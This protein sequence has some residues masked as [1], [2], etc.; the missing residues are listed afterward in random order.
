MED[1]SAFAKAQHTQKISIGFYNL[2]NLFDTTNNPN[3]LDDDFTPEG[4][5]KWNEYKYEKKLE[6]LSQVISKISKS[7]T[8]GSPSLL[9]VAEVENKQVLEDLIAT[10]YLQHENYGIVHYDSPDERG[11]DVALLY[12]KTDFEVLETK[13]IVLL[14]EATEGGRDYTRDILYVKGLLLGTEVHLLINHWPSRR[15]GAND[16][17][18]KRIAAAKRN[19]EI[20]DALL[21]ENAEARILLMGDFNDGP[22]SESIKTHL[23][24]TD[25]YNPML[26]LG[27]RYAGS[28]NHNFEWFIFDQILMTNNFVRMYDNKLLYEKSDIFNDYFIT[29]FDGRFKGNPFRTYAGDR[30][31]GGYSDHFPVYSVFKVTLNSKNAS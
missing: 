15:L 16:T 25:F 9:G 13:P 19:R 3:I 6:K 24:Q 1:T 5:R 8:G 28:L 17:Q 7:E 10:G 30:Y 22:H 29:E 14:L 11:I 4:I 20:I 23:V 31:L 12:K 18:H 27:T 2:E 26:Y 21:H